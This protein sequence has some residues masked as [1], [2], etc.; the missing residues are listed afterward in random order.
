MVRTLFKYLKFLPLVPPKDV[1]KAFKQIKTHG[2]SCNKFQTM[3][4]YFENNYIGKLVKNSSTIRKVPPYPI[5]RWNV[6][7]RVLQNKARTNNSQESW[8]RVFAED[9]HVHPTFNKLIEHFRLE[10]KNTDVIVSQIQSGKIF[11]Y[12]V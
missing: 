8:H 5:V 4:T 7:S 3:F 11:I 1:V 2:D 9:A 10:Q 6:H 12:N